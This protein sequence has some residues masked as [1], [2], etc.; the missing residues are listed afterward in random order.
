MFKKFQDSIE[1]HKKTRTDE[2]RDF[3]D[4]YLGEISKKEDP[5]FNELTLISICLDL[6]TAG[7]E[8]VGNTLT[9]CIMYLIL[10]PDIQES[11]WEEINE[12]LGGKDPEL[13]DRSR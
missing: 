7:A 9:F 2:P 3:L 11:V 8:S 12:V 5:D 1:E 10:F 4:V 13:S 6:F